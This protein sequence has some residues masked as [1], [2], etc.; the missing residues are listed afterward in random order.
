MPSDLELSRTH[1]VSVATVRRAY[2][3][4]V[5]RGWVQRVRKRGTV[6]ANVET[7]SRI[8]TVGIVMVADVPPYQ[9]LRRGVEQTLIEHGAAICTYWNKD[10]EEINNTQIS[11]AMKNGVEGLIVT[12]PSP[13]S[14]DLYRRMVAEG[15]PIVMAFNHDPF[16]HSVFPDDHRAGYLIGEHFSRCGY[17]NVAAVVRTSVIGRERLYGFREAIARHGLELREEATVPIQYVDEAGKLIADMGRREAEQI[18]KMNPLPEAVFVF[19][20]SHAAGVYHWLQNF[21]IAVPEQIAIA[22]VDHLG[23]EFHPFSLTSV[24]IGLEEIGRRAAELLVAQVQN[25]GLLVVQEKITPRLI[26]ARSTWN[27]APASGKN[28]AR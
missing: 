11:R 10:S 9:L 18:L 19:N 27:G 8:R 6:L 1:R 13:S 2:A 25:P 28:Y 3:E 14:F 26:V 23:P 20:D 5:E 22:A 15:I 4:L 16:V 7:R 21:G 12:P 17:K 24:D